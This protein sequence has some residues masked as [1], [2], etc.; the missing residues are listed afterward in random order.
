MYKYH[1]TSRIF[2]TKEEI[3]SWPKNHKKCKKCLRV[4]PL[5]RFHEHKLC[6]F[7]YNTVCKSCRV[8]DSS[9]LYEESSYESRLWNAARFRANKKGIPFSIAIS[10]IV[11]PRRCP[12][13]GIP[14]IHNTMSAPSLDR[15]RPEEGYVPGNI[16]VMSRRA[17]YLKSDATIKELEAVVRFLRLHE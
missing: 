3:A 8:E 10:D 17:N 7:G 9:R 16:V 5:H 14:M 13:L 12:I 11:I 2:F 15:I 6:L 4:L 1:R